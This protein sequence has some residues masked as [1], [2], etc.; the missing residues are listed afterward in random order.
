L[1]LFSALGHVQKRRSKVGHAVAHYHHLDESQCHQ[2][3]AEVRG[4]HFSHYNVLQL[5]DLVPQGSGIGLMRIFASGA[6]KA[7]NGA[8]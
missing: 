8:E 1:K 4:I 6:I 5:G 3:D 7:A 2:L